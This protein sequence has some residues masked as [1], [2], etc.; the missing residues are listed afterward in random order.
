MIYAKKRR[1][2]VKQNIYI[3]CIWNLRNLFQNSYIS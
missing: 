2:I 3:I 1:S